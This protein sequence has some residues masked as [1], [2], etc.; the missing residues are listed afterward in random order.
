MCEPIARKD[1][2]REREA[3][4]MIHL[5]HYRLRRLPERYYC[6]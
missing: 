1:R 4:S 6:C 5:F 3:S 2:E